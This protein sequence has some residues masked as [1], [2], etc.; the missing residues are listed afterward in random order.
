MSRIIETC[1]SINGRDGQGYGDKMKQTLDKFYDLPAGVCYALEKEKVKTMD[2]LLNRAAWTHDRQKLLAKTGVSEADLR[3]W[4]I[5]ADLCRIPGIRP[6]QIQE[7]ALSGLISNAKELGRLDNRQLGTWFNAEN[8]YAEGFIDQLKSKIEKMLPRVI[9]DDQNVDDY[10]NIL[11]GY[12][13]NG[14]AK[15]IEMLRGGYAL[16]AL[17]FFLFISGIAIYAAL[18]MRQVLASGAPAI[19]LFSISLPGVMV[20]IIN[21]ASIS[22]LVLGWAFGMSIFTTYLF[23]ATSLLIKS[24]LKNKLYRIIDLYTNTDQAAV[25]T[26]ARIVLGVLLSAFIIAGIYLLFTEWTIS[27]NQIIEVVPLIAVAATMILGFIDVRLF[28]IKISGQTDKRY[29]SVLPMMFT[30]R[31]LQITL[32]PLILLLAYYSLK[33]LG[34]AHDAWITKPLINLYTAWLEQ[35]RN[36]SSLLSPSQEFTFWLYDLLEHAQR[37]VILTPF[38]SLSV[39]S[40]LLYDLFLRMG[41]WATMTYAL[42]GAI[43]PPLLFKERK[44]VL[45]ILG[46]TFGAFLLERLLGQATLGLL[47][48]PDNTLFTGA[49]VLINVFLSNSAAE[50]VQDVSETADQIQCPACGETLEASAR[51]CSACGRKIQPS[52]E[53]TEH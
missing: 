45:L 7:I 44:K 52:E 49:L 14:I 19:L 18:T 23:P 27:E 38:T 36:T 10:E 40:S 13:V 2:A 5:A 25:L 39:W 42:I 37:Y 16:I 21:M 1:N 24:R 50:L 6:R 3:P 17:L 29:R 30:M 34:M 53:K 22:L 26:T 46:T 28:V 33:G 43:F 32:L 41:L 12:L 35:W 9:W 4:V 15:Q 31:L 20:L 48:L 51:F 11:K 47:D 8:G